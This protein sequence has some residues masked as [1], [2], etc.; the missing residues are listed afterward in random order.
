M[1]HQER[2]DRRREAEALMRLGRTVPP[3]VVFGDTN[4]L[5]PDLPEPFDPFDPF[6]PVVP[7]TAIE[8]SDHRFIPVDLTLLRPTDQDDG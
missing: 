4:P 5:L 7:S 2:N 6:D 1:A 8:W 3:P